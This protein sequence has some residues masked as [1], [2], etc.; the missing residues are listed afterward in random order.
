MNNN[1]IGGIHSLL[2]GIHIIIQPGIKRYVAIP[3][4]INLILFLSLFLFTRH[5]MSDFNLWLTQLLPGW[6]Q[7]LNTV[8]WVLFT[9][10]F[11]IIFIYTFV[12]LANL[13][14]APFNSL[15][16]ERVEFYLTGTALPSTGFLAQ[17]KDVPRILGRQL[18]II[19]YYIPRALL[20]LI[21]FFIPIIHVLATPIWFLFNAWLMAFTYLDYPTDNHRIPL[22]DVKIWMKQNR[23]SC[24]GFGI[25]VLFLSMIPIL[26][27]IVMPAAVA[28]GVKLWVETK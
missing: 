22:S 14:A 27:L 24:F 19:A 16:A 21:L 28:G 11:F 1:F 23:W 12:T 3:I 10:S 26:N 9:I 13:I 8:I 5:W 20:I 7:W 2:D 25:M 15:L 4:I 18:S 17:L 6:L